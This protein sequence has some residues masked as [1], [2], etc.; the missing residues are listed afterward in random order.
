MVWFGKLSALKQTEEKFI[1]QLSLF[2]RI[3]G[4]LTIFNLNSNFG[5]LWL[6]L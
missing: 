3:T 1:R 4:L 6:Q 5:V 2:F